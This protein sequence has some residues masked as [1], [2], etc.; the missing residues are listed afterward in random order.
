M[1]GSIAAAYTAW[2]NQERV[3]QVAGGV[4]ETLTARGETLLQSLALLGDKFLSNIHDTFI[5][6]SPPASLE[7]AVRQS[8]TGLSDATALSSQTN[9]AETSQAIAA[10]TSQTSR[11]M[12]EEAQGRDLSSD[13]SDYEEVPPPQRRRQAPAEQ[14]AVRTSRSGPG[15]LELNLLRESSPALAPS[16][17]G[18]LAVGQ[19]VKAKWQRGIDWHAGTITKVCQ[20]DTGDGAGTYEVTYDDGDVEMVARRLIKPTP[21]PS[22]LGH[23][24]AASVPAPAAEPVASVAT[25]AAASDP[26][27]EQIYSQLV[28][29][30]K[31]MKSNAGEEAVDVV[32]PAGWSINWVPR[33]SRT[34]S[35]GDVYFIPPTVGPRINSVTGLKAHLGLVTGACVPARSDVSLAQRF[36]DDPAGLLGARLSA[37][38]PKHNKR[39][40]SEVLM[41]R[42]HTIGASEV[43]LD[44]EVKYDALV[45]YESDAVEQ[46]EVIG[47]TPYQHTLLTEPEIKWQRAGS[48]LV[49]VTTMREYNG[50]LF[51]G[52][53]MCW[54]P[55]CDVEGNVALYKLYHADGDYEDLEEHEVQEGVRVHKEHMAGTAVAEEGA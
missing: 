14:P 36:Q 11:R 53:V 17:V 13:E 4:T 54:L 21:R 43:P 38:W 34:S 44:I 6:A 45:R 24:V 39:Y 37:T 41:I 55:A 8:L 22:A 30:S 52:E 12:R 29:A 31:E 3:M 10:E 23:A 46:W 48:E 33:K 32:G 15:S 51:A 42:K 25:N 7:S 28:N 18:P 16:L 35:K 50:K 27:A 5:A 1:G 20:A 26:N 49:G 9:A 19:C 47:A 2:R 40:T